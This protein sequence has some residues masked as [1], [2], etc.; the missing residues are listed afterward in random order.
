MSSVK[1][2]NT[3][4]VN[5]TYI[6]RFVKHE[7]APE[8]IL[9][10]GDLP[11]EDG[12]ILISEKYGKKFINLQGI[13]VGT[14]SNDLE[15]KINTFKE[16]FSRLSKNLDI[17]YNSGTL[18]YV[19]NCTSHEFDRDH[20][21]IGFVPWTAQFVV[22]SGIGEDTTETALETGDIIDNYYKTGAW[23]FAG[24][25]RPKPRIRLGAFGASATMP[26]GIEIK[27]TDTNER[28]IMTRPAG[29]E[30]GKYFELD[31]RL[32]TAKYDNVADHFYGVFP[33]WIVGVNNY[34]L[35][36]GEIIDQS[37]EM[38]E[39]SPFVLKLIHGNN[40]VAQSFM[41]PNSDDTYQV[42]S[43]YL[44]KTGTP[45]NNLVARIETDN[46]GKP[47][48][49]LVSAGATM[50][51]VPAGVATSWGWV[52]MIAAALFS[53]SA[54]TR[55]WIV[56]KTTAGDASNNYAVGYEWNA[57]A[58]YPRGNM[59]WSADAGS[60]YTDEP[61]ADCDFRLHYAGVI[62]N[63]GKDFRYYVDYYK[64]YL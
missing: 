6:P 8:R 50:S 29:M 3:E 15:S 26:C 42:L 40:Y 59:A 25:S 11:R 48:G 16:L 19:A 17:V 5:T 37:K 14:D 12:S 43:L 41:V 13:L 64:R 24:S 36:I 20:F 49:T 33:S 62:D 63:T 57:N 56:L 35:Y 34:R 58:N 31:C 21:N 55:Y 1:Y 4:I 30:N 28:F 9:N 44:V 53:L 22:V 23:T 60:T 54:N 7:S 46:G 18:R 61:L 2:D 51:V 52:R 10:Y 39:A 32:K 47:S 27:N 45:P 38:I